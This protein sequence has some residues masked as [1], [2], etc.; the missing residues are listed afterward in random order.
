LKAAFSTPVSFGRVIPIIAVAG[1]CWLVAGGVIGS[2]DA[3]A[4]QPKPKVKQPS[5]RERVG[6]NRLRAELGRLVPTGRGIVT[7][8]VEGGPPNG[9]MPFG[10]P[11]QF[12]K[13]MFIPRSGPSR[14]SGHARWT[15]ANMY[16]RVGMS[17]GVTDVHCF[18]ATH[19][20]RSG[21]LNV[22]TTAS[23]SAGPVRLFNH[24][25]I[26]KATRATA[27]S[28][29]RRVDFL[30]DSE[31][32]IVVAGVGNKADQ[33]LPPLLSCAY[34]AIAVG[35]WSGESSGGYTRV[36]E[37]GRCKPDLV[38][39]GGNVSDCTPMVAGIVACLL[40]VADTM[41]SDAGRAQV[42]KAVLMAGAEKPPGWAPEPGKPLARHYGAGR[43][44][45]DRSYHILKLGPVAPGRIGSRYGWSFRIA[46][47]DTTTSWRFDCPAEMGPASIILT[48]HRRIAGQVIQDPV[49]GKSQWLSTPRLADLD[50]KL[51]RIDDDGVEQVMA[52]SDGR[53]DNVEHIYLKKT[54]AGRYR[55]EVRR[56]DMLAEAWDFAVA[57]RID[58][59]AA[60]R[61]ARPGPRTAPGLGRRGRY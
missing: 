14:A 19:W 40:E 24:S 23:P 4:D 17:P 11:G 56:R 57:W 25:W 29:L 55:L 10:E 44:R 31:N 52:A 60:C 59:P 54:P 42:I 43:V 1:S 38:A 21:C 28:V 20:M 36:E 16:G 9:Y 12:P 2:A 51:I 7:G 15:A 49:S 26:S 5:G 47:P 35:Q 8:H 61:R 6:L 33:G 46:E 53:I 34:N 50:L 3:L 22:G 48:W 37:P 41:G 39:P 13:A 45:I 30:V 58:T 32:A 18:S 27:P